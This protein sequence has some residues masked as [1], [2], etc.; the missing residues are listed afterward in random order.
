MEIKTVEDAREIIDACIKET[1]SWKKYQDDKE[2]PLNGGEVEDYLYYSAKEYKNY[3]IK[4]AHS[5]GG[6]G[7][8]DSYG[9]IVEIQN[10]D[11]GMS[12]YVSYSGHYDSWNGVDWDYGD[13]SLVSPYQK[14][15]TC[16]R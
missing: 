4:T 6:E 3:S 9:L 13:I 16:W 14:T 1:D 11:T 7:E 15:T 10:K 12:T 8:G 2:E 5:W